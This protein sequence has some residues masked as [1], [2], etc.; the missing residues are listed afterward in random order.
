M[1]FLETLPRGM[2]LNQVAVRSPNRSCPTLHL[3]NQNGPG[4]CI[5]PKG[6]NDSHADSL[7]P[8]Y[9]ETADEI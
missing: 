1:C 6:P 4:I 7:A 8:V 2:F 5:L 9:L 3:L